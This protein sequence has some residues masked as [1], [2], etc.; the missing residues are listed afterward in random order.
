MGRRGLGNKDMWKM[1]ADPESG[2]PEFGG[3]HMTDI[4]AK[5]AGAPRANAMAVQLGCWLSNLLTNWIGDVGFLKK[6]TYQ[7]RRSLYRDSLATCTGEVVGKSIENGEHM[8]EL[9]VELED[10]NGD[11]MIPNGS[12]VVILPSRKLENWKS[13][14]P[15]PPVPPL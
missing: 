7:V 12:A 6:M 11:K 15:I 9:K 4:G 3:L 10:H 8:V 1:M 5:R 2:L 13:M 14:L